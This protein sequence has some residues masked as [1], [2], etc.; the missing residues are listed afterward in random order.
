MNIVTTIE[1]RLG[2]AAVFVRR[3]AQ[4]VLRMSVMY[5]VFAYFLSSNIKVCREVVV[6]ISIYV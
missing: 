5:S 1:T 6:F 2:R 3:F 4:I